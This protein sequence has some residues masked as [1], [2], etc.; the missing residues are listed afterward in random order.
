[1]FSVLL[2]SFF[3][4]LAKTIQMVRASV[5]SVAAGVITTV[6][7]F[8]HALIG[9]QNVLDPINS[10]G[11]T[12]LA[13]FASQFNTVSAEL[14]NVATLI[15][16]IVA[17]LNALGLSRLTASVPSA[18]NANAQRQVL[19]TVNGQLT[20]ATA[21]FQKMKTQINDAINKAKSELTTAIENVTQDVNSNTQSI[22][23]QID[24][25][26]QSLTNAKSKFQSTVNSAQ[27]PMNNARSGWKGLFVAIFLLLIVLYAI[28]LVLHAVADH[29]RSE[30]CLKGSLGAMA[31]LLLLWISLLLGLNNLVGFGL[32]ITCDEFD[33]VL[34]PSL[35]SPINMSSDVIINDPNGLLHCTVASKVT[36]FVDFLQL[37][38]FD[39]R[40]KVDQSFASFEKQQSQLDVSQQLATLQGN[41]NQFL[42]VST[43]QDEL[44]KGTNLSAVKTALT[45][46]AAAV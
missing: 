7:S 20:D 38:R 45:A 2:T 27:P 11:T 39:G 1:M 35:S 44:R 43:F 46:P 22:S 34:Q 31:F 19:N 8:P 9:M 33:D 26:L 28:M 23:N 16:Q 18:A 32:Q 3:D 15:P 5:V 17:A 40:A 4:Q 14:N 36:T 13:V 24:N 6:D 29:H 30:M 12:A 37:Q 41:L 25:V 21:T 42:K 10:F